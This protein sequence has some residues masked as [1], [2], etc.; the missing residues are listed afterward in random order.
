M[1]ET[2]ISTANRVRQ[3]DSK[4]HTAYIRSNRFKRYMGSSANSIFCIKEDLT[5]KPGDAISVPLIGALDSSGGPNDGSSDLV[6]NEKALPNDGH[7]IDIKVV[8][9]A[10][11]VNVEEEQ[12]SAVDIRNAGKVALKSLQMQ[13]LRNDIITNLHSINGLSYAASSQVQRDAW[14]ANNAD[15]VTFGSA[16]SN[17]ASN[18]HSAA[19]T[20]VDSTDDRLTGDVISMY[21]RRA[22]NATTANSEGIKP[23]EF[24]ED[25]ETFVMFVN[26]YA[27]RDARSWMVS[28]GYWENAMAR[29]KT[30]PLFSGPTSFEW[31]GVMVREIPEIG[32]LAGVGNG[33]ID[34]TPVFLCGAQAL[35]LAWA[36]RTK[37]TLRKE[38]DYEFRYGVGFLE[39]RGVSKFQYNQGGASAK[40]WSVATGYVSSVADV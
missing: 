15:R 18:D 40:D 34:V 9:D 28:K 26:S 27:F 3:W 23:Y 19:L 24:G 8:R 21:K 1:A 31:D 39:L 5:V 20:T 17:N 37:T 12:A 13:Y 6:G 11:L 38:T 10:V 2:V 25:M 36:K 4:A 32:A 33:G 16:V 22:Q 35:G 14:L 29:S 30:N 7:R